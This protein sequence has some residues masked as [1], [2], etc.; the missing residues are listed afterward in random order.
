MRSGLSVCVSLC[1]R[2]PQVCA[3]SVQTNSSVV[4]KLTQLAALSSCHPMLLYK[5]NQHSSI[6]EQFPHRRPAGHLFL[7]TTTIGVARSAL[8]ARSHPGAITKNRGLI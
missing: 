4:A 6:A 1:A 3:V 7:V 8:G 5:H 2:G